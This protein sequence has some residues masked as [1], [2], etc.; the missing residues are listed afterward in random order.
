MDVAG[1]SW[2]LELKR[3]VPDPGSGL[4]EAASLFPVLVLLVGAPLEG[5]L[6]LTSG[7]KQLRQRLLLQKLRTSLT[8]AAKAHEIKQPVARLLLQARA[9]QELK[10]RQG[11]EELDDREFE[12]LAEGIA[13]DARQVS[14]AIDSIR[15]LLDNGDRDLAPINLNQAVEAALLVLK[16]ELEEKRIQMLIRGLNH[17]HRIEAD[18]GQLQV[19]VINLVRNAIAAAGVEGRIEIT[20]RDSTFGVELSV[21]DDGPGFPRDV[22][23]LEDLFL[24]SSNP[25]GMG[26]GLFLVSCAVDNHRGSVH[27]SRSPLGGACITVRFPPVT[28]WR[29]STQPAS[30]TPWWFPGWFQAPS[31]GREG[32]S[33]K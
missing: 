10:Q 18:Q 24:A 9:I 19:M 30:A 17:H 12:V 14:V 1:Q 27:L 6:L 20:L 29:R 7:T 4:R 32:E 2:L 22:Q 31:S 25:E 16:G 33:P 15:N 28:S 8:A 13:R 23:Q 21:G 5:F 26:I 3:T 11:Q